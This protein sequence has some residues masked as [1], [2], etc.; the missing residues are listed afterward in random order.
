MLHRMLFPDNDPQQAHLMRRFLMGIA[1]S[2][3]VLVLL[4]LSSLFGVLPFGALIAVSVATLLL[5]L[6]FF[7][8]FR[9]GINKRFRDPSLTLA[10]IVASTL[11]ILYALHQAPIGHGTLSLIYLVP[12]LFG[13]FR[14]STPQLLGLTAFVSLSYAAMLALQPH[15]PA[16]QLRLNQ[17]ILRWIVLTTVLMFFSIMG[18]YVSSLR[19]KLGEAHAGLERALLRIEHLAARDELT[20]VL[21]RRSLVEVLD[22]QK[23][24]SDRYGAVFSILMVD[25]DHFKLVNDT[26]GHPAGDAVLARFAK[27]AAASLRQSDTFGR[28]GGEEFLAVLDQTTLEGACIVGERMCATAKRLQFDEFA[29]TL[30]VTVSLGIAQYR[31]R[32]DWHDLIKRADQA[33]YRAKSG[34]RDRIECETMES[35]EPV[36]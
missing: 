15:P 19:K 31:P 7:A 1:A 21:N 3:M 18:G 27:V 36:T 26:H 29:A 9:L 23:G 2:I 30:R 34:G 25:I 11:V 13:V 16:D 6:G 5:V 4:F 32:E 14:L 28:Y 12:F 17:D 8:V 33:L 22:Q 10:Q 24:R 20:G 35:Q